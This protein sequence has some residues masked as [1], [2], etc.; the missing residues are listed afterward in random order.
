[1]PYNLFWIVACFDIKKVRCKWKSAG[2][3]IAELNNK[4]QMDSNMQ[5]NIF[6]LKLRV[7]PQVLVLRHTQIL[8][9]HQPQACNDDIG[10]TTTRHHILD[11]KTLKHTKLNDGNIYRKRNKKKQYSTRDA[12]SAWQWRNCLISD[13]LKNFKNTTQDIVYVFSNCSAL[14]YDMYDKSC[15]FFYCIQRK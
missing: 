4:R 5:F 2:N 3:K 12:I 11:H 9:K 13:Q 10:R 1:M 14:C 7:S 15:A 6:W 8:T